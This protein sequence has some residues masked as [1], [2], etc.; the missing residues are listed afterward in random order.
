LIPIESGGTGPRREN[1]IVPMGRKG[2]IGDSP[3]PAMNRWAIVVHPYRGN[4]HSSRVS[5]SGN[6]GTRLRAPLPLP[7]PRRA[8]QAAPLHRPH[9]AREP[10]KR[11]SARVPRRSFIFRAKSRKVH[12][13]L[14]FPERRCLRTD[15]QCGLCPPNL[16][17]VKG[18]QRTPLQEP[19]SLR[20][21][22][23]PGISIFGF[24]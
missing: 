20:A 10:S 12:R 13:R 8:Q 6:V 21:K 19:G 24:G 11:F 14:P 15:Q 23:G 2:W 17:T 4:P 3:Y 5:R 22:S 16:T 7:C 1:S 18:Q 9:A